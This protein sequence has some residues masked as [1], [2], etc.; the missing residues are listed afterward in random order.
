MGFVN[1]SRI[2]IFA[3]ILLTLRTLVSAGIEGLLTNDGAS[4]QILAKYS[5]GYIF[6]GFIV[7]FVFAKLAQIQVRFL[8]TH[9]LLIIV[10]QEILGAAL[11][12]AIG[13]TNPPSSLW[14]VDW[15]V[16]VVSVLIGTEAGRRLRERKDS[17]TLSDS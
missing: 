11:L 13:L 3:V 16:L 4:A 15:A 14:L 8:Y 6:D 1:I 2:V 12:Y 9:V 17:E 7:I 5:I 10:L